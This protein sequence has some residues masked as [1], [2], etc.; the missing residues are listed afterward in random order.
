MGS[1]VPHLQICND[2]MIAARFPVPGGVVST[3]R[4]TPIKTPKVSL[5]TPK[6]VELQIALR[7]CC[8]QALARKAREE[9]R[10]LGLLRCRDKADWGFYASL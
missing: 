4:G 3:N 7:E 5:G 8:A 9:V 6:A 1:T 10:G 2:P